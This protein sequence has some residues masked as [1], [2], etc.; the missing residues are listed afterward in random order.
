MT[1]QQLQA[2]ATASQ[3]ATPGGAP[4]AAA[5]FPQPSTGTT[6]PT[7]LSTAAPVVVSTDGAH[8]SASA[9]ETQ[10]PTSLIQQVLDVLKDTKVESHKV[11][12]YLPDF[13]EKLRE[14]LGKEL[15]GQREHDQPA[16]QV[17]TP[18]TTSTSVAFAYRSVNQ[19]SISLSIHS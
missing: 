10:K 4:S 18:A 17:Q 9:Q 2:S 6:A 7:P 14:D 8:F 16:T 13:F 1:G 5:A 11:Q 19:T 12:K 15:R 3:T